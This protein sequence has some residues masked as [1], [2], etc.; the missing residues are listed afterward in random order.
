MYIW[1][2]AITINTQN[3]LSVFSLNA[4]G[5]IKFDNLEYDTNIEV[6]DVVNSWGVMGA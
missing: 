3:Q 2:T 5:V 6:N 4:L 1:V